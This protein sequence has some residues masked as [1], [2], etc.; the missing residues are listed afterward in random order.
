MSKLAQDQSLTVDEQLRAASFDVAVVFGFE[1]M[2]RLHEEGMID[3]EVWDN[4]VCNTMGY[5]G[6]PRV[7][8]FLAARPGPLSARLMKEIEKHADLYP[9][10]PATADTLA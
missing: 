9:L 7:R 2:L 6:H 4:V 5:L 1:N 10:S 3:P 8:A